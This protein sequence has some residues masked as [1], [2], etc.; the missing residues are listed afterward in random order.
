MG[1]DRSDEAMFEAVNKLVDPSETEA[2]DLL[3]DAPCGPLVEHL[4]DSMGKQVEKTASAPG[5]MKKRDLAVTPARSSWG[6]KSSGNL[7]GLTGDDEVEPPGSSQRRFFTCTVG[8]KPSSAKFYL[9]ET[10][11]VSELLAILASERKS[12]K[13][14]TK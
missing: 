8:R 5:S 4:S 1:D 10:D 7:C 14:E 2:L 6:G 12:I 3:K 11:E 13:V 9:D